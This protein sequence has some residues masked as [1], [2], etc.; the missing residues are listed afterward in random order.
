MQTLKQVAPYLPVAVV[1]KAKRSGKKGELQRQT[2]FSRA[3]GGEKIR[4]RISHQATSPFE[5]SM[6]FA[7]FSFLLFST[8]CL[9]GQ[10]D[11]S[12]NFDWFYIW[13]C[14]RSPSR[15]RGLNLCLQFINPSFPQALSAFRRK[16]WSPHIRLAMIFKRHGQNLPVSTSAPLL[17][18]R[19]KQKQFGTQAHSWKRASR[20]LQSPHRTTNP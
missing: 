15:H 10:A 6:S 11:G 19:L 16:C 5:G 3:R 20:A 17:L 14:K 12:Y 2:P 8:Q 9:W 7:D 4:P 18:S 13:L 1:K